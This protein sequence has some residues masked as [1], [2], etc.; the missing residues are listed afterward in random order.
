MA[1]DDLGR[2]G[3]AIWTA[4]GASKLNAASQALVREMARCA[5]TL[6]KLDALIVG[7]SDRWALLVF[8]DMGEVHL[9]IDK[10]LDE[11]RNHQLALK[12][13]FAE[14]RAAGIV[15]VESAANMAEP[16]DMLSRRRREREERE[17]QLG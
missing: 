3:R 1:T 7:K 13:L 15:P 14:V 6:D 10:V 9:S 2:T 5:D 16:E 4:Y 8:D 17:R 12:A 11:R